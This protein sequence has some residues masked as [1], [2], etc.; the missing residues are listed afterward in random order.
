MPYDRNPDSVEYI[1]MKGRNGHESEH[2]IHPT[3]SVSRLFT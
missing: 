3:E 1:E 2:R